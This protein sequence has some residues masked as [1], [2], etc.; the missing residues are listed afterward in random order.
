MLSI[1][2]GLSVSYSVEITVMVKKVAK[3]EIVFI[4]IIVYLAKLVFLQIKQT[5]KNVTA[6]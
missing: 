1:G 5:F 4:Y 6:F 3:A 2:G